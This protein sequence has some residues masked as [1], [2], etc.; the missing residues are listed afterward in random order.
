MI[1]TETIL[2]LNAALRYGDHSKIAGMVG[3]SKTTVNRF[4]NG[5]GGYVNDE[6]ANLIIEKA[7]EIIQERKKK[8]AAS[9][10]KIAKILER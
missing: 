9:Q 3:V 1:D 2:R 10:K 6:K 4:L 7:T 5:I 8:T